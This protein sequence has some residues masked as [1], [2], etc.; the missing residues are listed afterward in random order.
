M[1]NDITDQLLTVVHSKPKKRRGLRAI[2]PRE[3]S[4]SIKKLMNGCY[5]SPENMKITPVNYLNYIEHSLNVY[6]IAP[7]KP[8]TAPVKYMMGIFF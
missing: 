3:M 7:V 4:N 8:E 6:K 2:S 5:F 1:V